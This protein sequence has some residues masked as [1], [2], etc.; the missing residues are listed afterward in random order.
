[1]SL[2]GHA[3][4]QK[5]WHSVWEKMQDDTDL[6]LASHPPSES[7]FNMAKLDRGEPL[8]PLEFGGADKAKKAVELAGPFSSP[9]EHLDLSNHSYT[10]CLQ[11]SCRSLNVYK[12][13]V[14]GSASDAQVTLK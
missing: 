5:R 2:D 10:S 4:Y 13:P 12:F 14:E 6:A 3:R 8:I 11:Q 7:Q 1:M 9:S